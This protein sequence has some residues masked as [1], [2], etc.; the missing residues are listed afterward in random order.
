MSKQ[1]IIPISPELQFVVAPESQ[2]VDVAR[3]KQVEEIPPLQNLQAFFRKKHWGCRVAG[4]GEPICEPVRIGKWTYTPSKLD[5][6]LLHPQARERGQ[7]ILNEGIPVR[8]WVYGEEDKPIVTPEI[9]PVVQ[10]TVE[11]KIEPPFVPIYEPVDE[12]ELEP[13]IEQNQLG[14]ELLEIYR[15]VVTISLVGTLVVVGGALSLLAG[16]LQSAPIPTG[17]AVS[18]SPRHGITS[19]L[20]CGDPA[21]YCMLDDQDYRPDRQSTI[22]EVYRW[23]SD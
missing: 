15:K 13:V 19:M 2:L 17:T 23:F 4:E 5:C 21:L 7:A 1:T 11:P 9:K 14:R 18:A 6:P 20:W 8:Q 3:L 12:P 22:V 16:G 10:P